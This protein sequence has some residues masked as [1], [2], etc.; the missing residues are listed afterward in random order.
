MTN[1]DAKNA[2]MGSTDTKASM[3]AAIARIESV[4]VGMTLMDQ[5][6]DS[7]WCDSSA[8]NWIIEAGS[9]KRGP[10]E[11]LDESVRPSVYE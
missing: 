8:H 1:D 7:D 4:P 3:L 5:I 6:S 10:S 9:D 2:L 11:E